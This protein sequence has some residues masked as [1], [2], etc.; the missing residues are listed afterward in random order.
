LSHLKERK[1]NNC[2]NC[3]A[4][5][6]GRFCHICGQ[7]N[8][9]TKESVWHLVNHF[10]QDI[11]HFDGKFF[12]SLKY[13]ITKP[14][15]LSKEYMAGRRASYLN[16]IRMYIFT[17]AFFFLIFFGFYK[18]NELPLKVSTS[19]AEMFADLRKNRTSLLDSLKTV[20]P[21][22]QK[23]IIEDKLKDIEGDISLL[24]RDSTATDKLKSTD[25]SF[26][27]ISFDKESTKKYKTLREYDSVQN[28]LPKN[29]RNGFIRN[30]MERQNLHL[31]EKYKNDG[32][33][34]LRGIVENFIQR[35]PQILFVSLPLFALLLRMLYFR[36][37][38]IFY[39]NHTILAIHIYCAVFIII[40]SG[41][42]LG[43]IFNKLGGSMPEWLNTVLVLSGFFY[44]YKS[45]RN[46]YQQRRAK[47]IFK[48]SLFL[49]L[50]LILMILLFTV[51]F[52]FSTFTI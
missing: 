2:L 14:G 44:I 46:F 51:F 22:R 11:T 43:S 16:P 15:F 20:L 26:N 25:Y 1:E 36:Q 32:R 30:K 18:K 10:F 29:Q 39:V 31:K 13:L 50:L 47:T 24:E 35:F 42:W 6:Q 38:D 9:E 48:Y 12:S 17:S 33:A 52:I 3:N 34:T 37:K 5:I 41:L 8:V 45:L 7:E 28:A 27:A 4:Q 19:A 40:L 49:F 21:E 23:I